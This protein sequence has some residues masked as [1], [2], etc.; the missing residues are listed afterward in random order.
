MSSCRHHRLADDMRQIGADGE[1]PVHP[2]CSQRGPGDETAPDPEK[3]AQDPNQETDDNQINRTDVRSR[4]REM[5]CEQD[6]SERP[7]KR[8]KRKVVTISRRMAW[9]MIKPMETRA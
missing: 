8:R 4:D 3:P 5:H 9:P 2:D 7:R 6:H 1:V